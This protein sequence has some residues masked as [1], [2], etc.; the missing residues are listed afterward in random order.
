VA[1]TPLVFSTAMEFFIPQITE[2]LN[3][4]AT[5]YNLPAQEILDR[6]TKPKAPEIKKVPKTKVKKVPHPVHTHKPMEP[7][8][9]CPLCQSHGDIM[10]PVEMVFE[11]V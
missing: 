9:D 6:Y 1:T 10:K 5:E 8:T 2:L 4:I 7:S 11:A 3:R